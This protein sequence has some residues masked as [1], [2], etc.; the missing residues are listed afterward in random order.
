MNERIKDFF[1]EEGM[2]EGKEG[3]KEG[4]KGEGT[5][6]RRNARRVGMEERNERIIKTI[7]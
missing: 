5:K 2:K 4:R 3:T 7:D 6:E 1:R